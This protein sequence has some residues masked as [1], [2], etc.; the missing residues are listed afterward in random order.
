MVRVRVKRAF[1]YERQGFSEKFVPGEKKISAP[2]KSVFPDRHERVI[3]FGRPGHNSLLIWQ[4]L[5]AVLDCKPDLAVIMAGTNDVVWRL[6][7][8]NAVEYERCL[9]KICQKLNAA[10]CRIILVTIPPCLEEFV[11]KREKC[12]P[13]ETKNLMPRINEINK[14]I[15]KLGSEYDLPVADFNAIFTGDLRSKKSML[16]NP[17]NSGSTDGVHP[18]PGGYLKLAVM[19]KNIIDRHGLPTGRIACIGD[20]ITYGVHVKGSGSN[21]GETYPGQLLKLLEK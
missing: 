15:V 11:A 16:R 1:V 3:N 21:T 9:R 18:T 13:E 4:M 20:S 10:G 19:L 14:V 6:R 12:T 8:Q 17:L 7:W 5:D 2:E